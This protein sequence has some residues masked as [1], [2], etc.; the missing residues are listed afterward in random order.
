MA[1]TATRRSDIDRLRLFACVLTL[2]VFHPLTVFDHGELTL[3]KSATRSDAADAASR[4]L[5]VFLMPLFFLLA[6]MSTM[7]ALDRTPAATLMRQRASRLLV[8]FVAGVVLL[9][10][11]IKYVELLDGRNIGW[12]GV[13]ATAAPPPDVV[14]FLRRFFTHPNWFSWAHLWF[15]FY[16]FLL[17]AL[18]LPLFRSLRRTGGTATTTTTAAALLLSLAVL[19]VV[20]LVLRPIYPHHLPNLIAD[21]A[22]IC[23]YALAMTVGA[24][25]IVFPDSERVLQ[26]W[27]PLLLIPLVTGSV[28]YLTAEAPVAVGL[29]RAITLWSMLAVLVGL[30]PHIGRGHLRGES[31][32]SGAVL[33]AYVLHLLPLVLVSHYVKDAPWPLAWRLAVIMVVGVA[34]TA[35]LIGLLRLTPATRMLFGIPAPSADRAGAHE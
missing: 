13:I 4:L 16:L 8:P 27:W 15:L 6:G 29:A 2:F 12:R 28:L 24:A 11:W 30:G 25:M 18:L 26:R 35:V 23:V 3:I 5:H 32:L 9:A 17:T 33:P 14:E 21:W 1:P 19:V 34:A 10:P 7:M 31:A 20:E 22:S